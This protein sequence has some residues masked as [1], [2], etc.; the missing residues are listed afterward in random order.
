MCKYFHLTE[1][2]DIG[3]LYYCDLNDGNH[4]DFFSKVHP[5]LKKTGRGL[6]INRECLFLNNQDMCPFSKEL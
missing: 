1:Y 3:T 4:T 6:I 5:I 2:K